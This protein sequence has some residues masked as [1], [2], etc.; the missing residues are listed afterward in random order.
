MQRLLLV[1]LGKLGSR[2]QQLQLVR[3]DWQQQQQHP[4]AQQQQVRG[5]QEQQGG[6]GG[7]LRGRLGLQLW[8]QEL[9]T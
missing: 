5:L 8:R 9:A 4:W 3:R 6:L 2:Q 7:Y 1:Q